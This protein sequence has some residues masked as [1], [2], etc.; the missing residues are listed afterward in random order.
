MK[1]GKGLVRWCPDHGLDGKN[2]AEAPRFVVAAFN[3]TREPLWS[4]GR[5]KDKARDKGCRDHLIR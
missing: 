2:E 3:E 4:M 5:R 1:R